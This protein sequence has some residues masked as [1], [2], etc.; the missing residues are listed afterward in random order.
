M[1]SKYILSWLSHRCM[2][3]HAAV[4]SFSAFTNIQEL[5][6]SYNQLTLLSAETMYNGPGRLGHFRPALGSI[7]NATMRETQI[8][9]LNNNR[10]TVVAPHAFDP[11]EGL[12]ALDLSFNFITSL[13][14]GIFARFGH[15]KD[16]FLTTLNQG[17][18]PFV[19]QLRHHCDAQKTAIFPPLFFLA[20]TR[21]GPCATE[22]PC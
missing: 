21:H 22:C 1:L 10:I 16:L 2:P 20:H 13:P 11:F 4:D 7:V 5:D 14:V 18:A 12:G 15:L 6:L 9:W 8:L 19:R 3:Q 17:P